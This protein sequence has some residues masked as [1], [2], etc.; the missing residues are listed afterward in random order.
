MYTVDASFG[1][2]FHIRS[3]PGT[4]AATTFGGKKNVSPR[5]RE[6]V[7]VTPGANV[8]LVNARFGIAELFGSGAFT[9][10]SPSPP[11]GATPRLVGLPTLFAQPPPFRPKIPQLSGCPSYL[12]GN[13][14][15][16]FGEPSTDWF[17]RHKSSPPGTPRID[18]T[19]TVPCE[20]TRSLGSKPPTINAS[21]LAPLG[22]GANAGK[23]KL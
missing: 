19:Y 12:K 5:F 8:R 9:A 1:A 13:V 17:H 14:P 16:E 11:P 21:G 18:S 3:S 22:T 6:F 4:S 2:S 15:F 7:A 10:M 23:H 20:S